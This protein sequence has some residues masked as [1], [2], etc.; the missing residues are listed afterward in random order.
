MTTALDPAKGHLSQ[1]RKVIANAV[2]VGTVDGC[3]REA[4][5]YAVH[6][7]DLFKKRLQPLIGALQL[8]AKVTR[9]LR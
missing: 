8:L 5:A 7:V 1:R 9:R 2:G 6:F 3:Y 4:S